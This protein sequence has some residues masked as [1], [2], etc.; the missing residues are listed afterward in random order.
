MKKE[1]ETLTSFVS[2]R[3]SLILLKHVSMIKCALAL[4]HGKSLQNINNLRA[5]RGEFL[6]KIE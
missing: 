3:N 5:S 4:Y 1:S 6:G 2:I